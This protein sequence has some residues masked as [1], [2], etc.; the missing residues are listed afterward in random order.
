VVLWAGSPAGLA[1]AYYILVFIFI[2]PSLVFI[3]LA[4]RMARL[5][6]LELEPD[7][8]SMRPED[9]EFVVWSVVPALGILDGLPVWAPGVVPGAT[10]WAKAALVVR[11]KA[12]AKIRVAFMSKGV[13][14]GGKELATV[15]RYTCAAG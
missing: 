3:F 7:V 4:L 8:L 13:V 15:P 11:A 6:L 9:E 2:V 12:A 14:E 1:K 5:S 10:V